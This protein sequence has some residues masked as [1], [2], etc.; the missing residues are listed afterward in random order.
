M[1]EKLTHPIVKVAIDALQAG[2]SEAWKELF[3]P[4]A[5]LLDDGHP[6]DL[7]RFSLPGERSR[8]LRQQSGG[9]GLHF[10]MM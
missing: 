1:T 6:R 10:P 9:R 2:D 8:R 4:D 5:V 7:E 3:D